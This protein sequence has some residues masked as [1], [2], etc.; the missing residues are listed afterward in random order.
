MTHKFGGTV[1]ITSVTASGAS[2]VSIGG[3]DYSAGM[4]IMEGNFTFDASTSTTGTV[5][6][7]TVS[8]GGNSTITMGGGSGSI[9]V[10]SAQAGG[11][12]SIDAVQV[13]LEQLLSRILP[14]LALSRSFAGKGSESI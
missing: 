12:F 6:L 9:A 4:T 8:A 13:S 5:T 10:G 3:G 1:D 7:T 14:V 11:S 2:T